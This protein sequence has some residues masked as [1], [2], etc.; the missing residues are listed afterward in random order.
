M[1]Q[2]QIFFPLGDDGGAVITEK[3]SNLQS[4]GVSCS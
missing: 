1:G 4:V 2:Q 3:A